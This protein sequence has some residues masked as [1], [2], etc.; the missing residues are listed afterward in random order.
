MN[1]RM[2]KYENDTP[3]FKKR[4]EKNLKLYQSNQ[5]DNFDKFDVNS[6]ISILKSNARNIDVDQIR[7]MLDKKYRDNLPKRKSI[8]I[9]V[10]EY[11]NIPKEHED[12]KEYDINAILSKAKENKNIDYHQERLNKGVDNDFKIIDEINQK[13]QKRVEEND[14]ESELI[15]LI[16]TITELELKNKDK[17]KDADLLNL[18]GD[19]NTITL[20]P[21]TDISETFNSTAQDN[22]ESFYTG[23]L[24]IKDKD[25]DDFKDIEDDIKSNSILIKILIFI[26]ILIIIGVGVILLNKFLEL[27]LF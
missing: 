3:E 10:E 5:L 22:I 8:A 27:G 6:N 26:F 21:A 12:T 11:S 9:D 7:E 24:K 13:Y 15:N 18:Q 25:Y 19:E 4:T 23:K 14:D 1:S 20:K 17:D 2:D 16:N